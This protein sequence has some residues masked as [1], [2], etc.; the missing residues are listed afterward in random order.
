MSTNS[1]FSHTK[2]APGVPFWDAPQAVKDYIA[3]NYINTG[4]MVE[5]ETYSDD[6]KTRTVVQTFRDE[7]SKAEWFTDTILQENARNRQ[8][9]IAAQGH[10]EDYPDSK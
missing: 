10:Q 6:G 2:P 3:T 4:K 8:A 7:A 9:W 1:T 5:M